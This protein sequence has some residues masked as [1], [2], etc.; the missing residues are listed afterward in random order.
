MKN[1][2]DT[3]EKR[4]KQLIEILK[5]TN[6]TTIAD[7]SKQLDVSEMTI[8][9]DCAILSSMGL[10]EQTFGKV[11][12]L[13][14]TTDTNNETTALCKIHNKLAQKVANFIS[15]GQI[16]FINTSSTAIRTLK[17]LTNKNFIV[18][19]NNLKALDYSYNPESTLLLAG[20][21]VRTTKKALVGDLA[22][23]AFHTMRADVGIIG[24]TGLDLEM[25]IST[26]QIHEARINREII[27]N[28]SKLILVADYRKI[29]NPSNFSVG[30]FGDID[31]LI[32]DPF[33]NQGTLQLISKQGVEVVQVPI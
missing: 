9:R 17:F 18:L 14:D 22:F 12:I 19:T 26:S 15:N 30:K 20:G 7:L 8:R 24:C 6:E 27:K 23:N 11:A 29:G 33:A 3:I 16:I 10:I 2:N 13:P 31:L 1:S 4:R 25:G 5:E 32:T 28:S 21:E